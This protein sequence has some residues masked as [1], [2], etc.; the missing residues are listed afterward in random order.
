MASEK[1]QP[2]LVDVCEPVFGVVCDLNRLGR[3]GANESVEAVANEVEAAFAEVAR[4][5]G[6]SNHLERQWKEVEPALCCFVDSMI[7]GSQLPAGKDW[8]E[9]RMR[10]PGRLAERRFKIMTGEDSFYE[11]FLEKELEQDA[12]NADSLERLEVYFACLFLGFEGGYSPFPEKLQ[13]IQAKVAGRVRQLLGTGRHDRVTP[14]AYD[15]VNTTPLNLDSAPAL[16]GAVILSILFVL[17]F[18]VGTGVMYSMAV[19]NLGQ[20]V[21]TIN[22]TSNK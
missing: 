1:P 6:R 5:I 16:W 19:K 11:D 12:G 22:G 14:E 18:A 2:R 3:A 4:L 8:R 7:E 21:G 13:K 10:E 15:H 9:P 20:A 17:M